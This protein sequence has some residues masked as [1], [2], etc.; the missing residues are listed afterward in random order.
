MKIIDYSVLGASS[1]LAVS[2][3][4]N[5]FKAFK[6]K[7]WKKGAMITLGVLVAGY[8]FTYALDK[9]KSPSAPIVVLEKA[10]TPVV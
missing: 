9:I 5:G 8:A 2:G 10:P 4:L 7:E 3:A 6:G 1:L